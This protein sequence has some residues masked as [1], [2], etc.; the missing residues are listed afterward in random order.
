MGLAQCNACES[1]CPAMELMSQ[2]ERCDADVTNM[3]IS[4]WKRDKAEH[5]QWISRMS[6]SRMF[7]RWISHSIIFL[8]EDRIGYSCSYFYEDI[9]MGYDMIITKCLGKLL[10]V[11]Y[12]VKLSIEDHNPAGKSLPVNWKD[13]GARVVRTATV[14]ICLIVMAL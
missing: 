13:G 8:N 7:S 11:K 10:I 2:T 12:G 5:L 14:S 6:L 1:W 4:P 9:F 3:V